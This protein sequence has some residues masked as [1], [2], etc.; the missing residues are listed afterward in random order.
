MFG[1][2]APITGN[3]VDL[4]SVVR[5]RPLVSLLS[6]IIDVRLI[7]GVRIGGGATER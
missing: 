7:V 5:V 1:T 4:G 3:D 2:V 6:L